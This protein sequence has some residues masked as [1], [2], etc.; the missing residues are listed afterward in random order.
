MHW[1][2]EL[3]LNPEE[4]LCHD[5]ILEGLD[6]SQLIYKQQKILNS[7][8]QSSPDIEN[9]KLLEKYKVKVPNEHEGN[10]D[11]TNDHTRSVYHTKEV[12]TPKG[13]TSKQFKLNTQKITFQ[14]FMKD[15]PMPCSMNKTNQLQVDTGGHYMQQNDDEDEI[16][17]IEQQMNKI[18]EPNKT[19]SE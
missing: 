14:N 3:R 2:P 5:W 4:A 18:D 13:V 10:I 8:Y 16:A 15:D 6:Y 19:S 1:D 11:D 12:S 7:Q 9:S 17:L